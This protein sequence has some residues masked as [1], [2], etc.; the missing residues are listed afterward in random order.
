MDPLMLIGALNAVLFPFFVYVSFRR[1]FTQG[2][3]TKSGA[4]LDQTYRRILAKRGK[5]KRVAL[6]KFRFVGR[7]SRVS[8]KYPF[9]RRETNYWIRGPLTVGLVHGIAPIAHAWATFTFIQFSNNENGCPHQPLAEFWMSV[10]LVSGITLIIGLFV[11][12][13]LLPLLGR[14]LR[15]KSFLL[16]WSARLAVAAFLASGYQFFVESTCSVNN[17][18]ALAPL[19]IY[20]G[21][22]A[23][24]VL[25][26]RLFM[27]GRKR[28]LSKN[29]LVLRVFGSSKRSFFLFNRLQPLWN[30]VGAVF[31][32]SSPD[33]VTSVFFSWR[34]KR[35]RTLIFVALTAGALYAQYVALMRLSIAEE[36]IRVGAA[37]VLALV[38]FVLLYVPFRW[39]V[40]SS[41]L[42]D[43]SAVYQQIMAS[44]EGPARNG[45]YSNTYYSCHDDDWQTV[46]E[47]IAGI[48]DAVLID[49]RGFTSQNQGTAFEISFVVNNFPI[50]NVVGLADQSTEI[51]AVEEVLKDAWQHMVTTSPNAGGGRRELTIYRRRRLFGKDVFKVAAFLMNHSLRNEK[52]G[53]S[54]DQLRTL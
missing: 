11:F 22:W 34:P 37:V 44:V 41:F 49:L 8:W 4:A 40:S 10:F 9:L 21:I 53:L 13:R 26:E 27:R 33:Q 19:S 23:L 46:I 48:V 32:I 51:D 17:S 31:T 5:K 28:S 16:R 18:D 6:P 47:G 52:L 42:P 30:S 7:W 3:R 24:L 50:E 2:M 20:I 45:F 14:W 1:A 25:P 38:S 29:L 15:A 54:E 39:M 36:T 12:T 35:L 43:E